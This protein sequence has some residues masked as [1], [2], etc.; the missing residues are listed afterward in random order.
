MYKNRRHE[1][2]V[3]TDK[4]PMHPYHFFPLVQTEA[5]AKKN[6]YT[7]EEYLEHWRNKY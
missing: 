4:C 2:A 5:W 3:E 6:G 1:S 7:Y